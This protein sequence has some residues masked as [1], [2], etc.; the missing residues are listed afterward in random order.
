MHRASVAPNRESHVVAGGDR[1]KAATTI[2]R[3]QRDAVDLSNDITA[4]EQA[5][6]RT[7]VRDAGDHRL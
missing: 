7:S 2:P 5:I 1:G 6:A 4:L 3:Q